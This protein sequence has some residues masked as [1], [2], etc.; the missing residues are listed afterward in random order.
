MKSKIVIAAWFLMSVFSVNA[1]LNKLNNQGLIHTRSINS[2]TNSQELI[3]NSHLTPVAKN[4]INEL[5]KTTFQL[6]AKSPF[7]KVELLKSANAAPIAIYNRPEGT[8]PYS[9]M[10]LSAGADV[11]V[12]YPFQAIAGS[13]FTKPWDFR[14][15]STNATSYSWDWGTDA[16]YSTV[17]D[18]SFKV[19]NLNF[20]VKGFYYAPLLKSISGVDTSY[21]Y[22]ADLEWEDG[23]YPSRLSAS[24]ESAYVGLADFY[25]N[26]AQQNSSGMSFWLYSDPDGTSLD[27]KYDGFVFGSCRREFDPIDE[28]T[29]A[30]T[31]TNEVI[32]AYEKPMSPLVIKDLTYLVYSELASP[33]PSNTSLLLSVVKI[34]ADGK[35]TEDTIASTL[36]YASDVVSEGNNFFYLPAMFYETDPDTGREMQTSIRVEDEFAVVLSGLDQDG[37]NF[38]IF[39]DYG[40]KTDNSSFFGKV[41]EDTGEFYGYYGSSDDNGLNVYLSLNAYFDYLYTDEASRILR[42]GKN[43][44]FALDSLGQEGGFVY[45]FFSDV[46]DSISGETLIWV[47]DEELPEWVNISYDNSY[48]DEYEGLI[49]YV[50]ATQ[51]PEG[52][53][54]RSAEIHIYSLGAE[55]TIQLIQNAYTSTENI[56]DSKPSWVSN[57]TGV[58][59]NYSPSIE[60]V[61]VYDPMGRLLKEFKADLSGKLQIDLPVKGVYMIRVAGR[62]NYTLKILR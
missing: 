25:G 8:Y 44:G 9:L 40:N 46:S 34:D 62:E 26:T 31:R 55:A 29:V 18:A 49:F 32:V 19:D 7:A 15:L 2:Y 17:K 27:T 51:L 58:E 30:N 3:P 23:V 42:I 13:A 45:S 22:L 43:G 6:T 35:L 61:S 54:E 59:L 50:Q 57:S 48:Y 5:G 38:G 12:S 4:K 56:L 16:N 11:G 14:N 33:I 1:K 60:E 53:L 28:T 47:D 41:N 36:I 52:V 10:G 21:Y 24:A 39:S 37:V 20:L